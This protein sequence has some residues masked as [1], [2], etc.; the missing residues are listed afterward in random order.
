MELEGK[1]TPPQGWM[2]LRGCELHVQQLIT[3]ENI[4]KERCCAGIAFSFATY[5]LCTAKDE[6]IPLLSPVRAGSHSVSHQEP[7]WQNS[8]TNWS[9]TNGAGP[10]KLLAL[11]WALSALMKTTTRW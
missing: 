8:S 2:Q 7:G 10:E 11:S 4:L 9:H 5:K 1:D 6:T 3:Q